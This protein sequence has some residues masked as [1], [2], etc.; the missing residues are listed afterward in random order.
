MPCP[1]ASL[2]AGWALVLDHPCSG[3][4]PHLTAGI[5]GESLHFKASGSPSV[6]QGLPQGLP[7]RVVQSHGWNNPQCLAQPG[8]E[9]EPTGVTC[10]HTATSQVPSV[11]GSSSS[12]ASPST[13]PSAAS[14]CRCGRWSP[15]VWLPQPV[16]GRSNC[17]SF[18]A[19]TSVVS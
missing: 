10:H 9:S 17:S 1:Q 7:P 16:W 2:V 19:R 13:C 4:A 12:A 8:R 6:R 15:G 14:G 11:Q 5:L 3:A 18:S